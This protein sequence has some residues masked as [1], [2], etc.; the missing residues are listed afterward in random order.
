MFSYTHLDLGAFYPKQKRTIEFPYEGII[1]SSL[2]ASCGC[3][4]V[5]NDIE[6]KKVKVTYTAGDFPVHLMHKESISS[7]K[8]VTVKYHLG[9]PNNVLE[10]KLTFKTTVI[11]NAGRK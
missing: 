9:D 11:N 5:I 1:I 7:E 10:L 6:E 2:T 3:S 8:Y 4:D